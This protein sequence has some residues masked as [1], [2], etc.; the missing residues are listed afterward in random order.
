MQRYQGIQI[1][2]EIGSAEEEGPSSSCCCCCL[3]V[4]PD[5]GGGLVDAAWPTVS[6]HPIL[7][8]LSIQKHVGKAQ[9]H[10]ADCVRSCFFFLSFFFFFFWKLV[11]WVLDPSN[12]LLQ[13]KAAPLRTHQLLGSLVSSSSSFSS[14]L[15][16]FLF[17]KKGGRRSH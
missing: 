9:E 16:L 11:F 13:T 2:G 3:L 7:L 8:F 5:R 14:F 10:P 12:H 1:E 15:F 6:C 17:Y 4:G